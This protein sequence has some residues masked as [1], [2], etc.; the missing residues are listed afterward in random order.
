MFR[1]G[2]HLT[3]GRAYRKRGVLH[4]RNNAAQF[5][6]HG[7]EGIRDGAGYFGGHLG[8][9]GQVALGHHADFLKQL[10]NTGLD[11]VAFLARLNQCQ[12]V[13]EHGVQ[14]LCHHAQFIARFHSRAGLE[15]AH[16]DQ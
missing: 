12:C 8:A 1:R 13:I 5:H 15:V 3:G 14:R 4:L 2:L 9:G 11:V 7:V 16:A 10:L 6:D